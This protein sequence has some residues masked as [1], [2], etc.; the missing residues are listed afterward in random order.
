MVPFHLP[1]FLGLGLPNAKLML[2]RQLVFAVTNVHQLLSRQS[3]RPMGGVV[4]V[5]ILI[6]YGKTLMNVCDIVGL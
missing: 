1:H 2:P 6:N 3:L 5:H 4:E